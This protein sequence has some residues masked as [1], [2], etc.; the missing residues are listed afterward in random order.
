M[1]CKKKAQL[2]ALDC[3]KHPPW[4]RQQPTG[5]LEKD[6][7]DEARQPNARP[8]LPTRAARFRDNT[9]QGDSIKLS[10]IIFT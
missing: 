3:T 4:E 1:S 10:C 5:R 2:P 7:R 8:L 6:E 9:D